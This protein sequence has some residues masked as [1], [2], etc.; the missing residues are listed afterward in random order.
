MA[1]NDS[2]A[3]GESRCPGGVSCALGNESEEGDWER[4]CGS[5]F[6]CRSSNAAEAR[7]RGGSWERGLRL[8][9]CCA[10]PE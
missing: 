8:G 10:L 9:G 7:G 6:F 4:G 2:E 5:G 1:R 3:R